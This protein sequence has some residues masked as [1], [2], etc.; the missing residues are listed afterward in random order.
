MLGFRCLWHVYLRVRGFLLFGEHVSP[1]IAPPHLLNSTP[2]QA[3]Q[4][5]SRPI[6][7]DVS[8]AT[9]NVNRAQYQP[10][11]LLLNS[12]SPQRR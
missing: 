2:F 10:M 1:L 7:F 11:S 3:R 6:Y 12:D 9:G 4:N 8:F 5:C